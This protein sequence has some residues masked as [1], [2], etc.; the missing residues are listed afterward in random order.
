M[1]EYIVSKNQE[2]DL[3][4]IGLST[5]VFS[6]IAAACIEDE[7]R[8]RVAPGKSLSKSLS[9]KV[10]KNNIVINA[11][12]LVTTGNN[13]N[14]LCSTLQQRIYTAVSQMTGFKN[15]IVNLNV[16]GFYYQ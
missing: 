3:G 9:C 14:A 10:V 8:I 15:I 6:S 1:A 13:L 12:V 4:I 2:R 5:R 16:V 11:N 7:D